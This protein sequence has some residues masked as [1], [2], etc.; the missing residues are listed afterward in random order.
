VLLVGVVLQL[1]LQISYIQ[2]C[3][4]YHALLYFLVGLNVAGV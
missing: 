2:S 4:V 1:L 3:R